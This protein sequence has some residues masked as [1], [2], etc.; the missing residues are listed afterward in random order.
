MGN[1]TKTISKAQEPAGRI[2]RVQVPLAKWPRSASHDAVR[3]LGRPAPGLRPP[4]QF[5]NASAGFVLAQGLEIAKALSPIYR[6][7]SVLRVPIVDASS[8]TLKLSRNGLVGC[9]CHCIVPEPD[10]W[11]G[12]LFKVRLFRNRNFLKRPYSRFCAGYSTSA[13]AVTM[14]AAIAS[15]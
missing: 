1:A 15:L 3:A 5:H 2:W 13:L 9:V 11:P 8:A 4:N 6:R 10:F 7:G 14:A 12:E